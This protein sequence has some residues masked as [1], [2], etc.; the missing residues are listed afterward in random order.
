MICGAVFTGVTHNRSYEWRLRIMPTRK[1]G[2][3]NQSVQMKP[4]L[5]WA[6][7]DSRGNLKGINKIRKYA[8][9]HATWHKGRYRRWPE[10]EAKGW[11][12]IRV[13]LKETRAE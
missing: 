5:W 7:V 3:L 8:V 6:V 4:L 13:L 2:P 10:L 11:R 12:I 9:S 1:R